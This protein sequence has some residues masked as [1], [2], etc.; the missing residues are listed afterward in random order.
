MVKGEIPDL[1]VEAIDESGAAIVVPQPSP[2][3]QRSW[4][5][6]WSLAGVSEPAR[7]DRLRAYFAERTRG[8]SL[9][10]ARRA[11]FYRAYYS[12]LPEDRGRP[13][14]RTVL[15]FDCILQ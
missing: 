7:E 14:I 15:L 8:T 10:H 3:T 12:V 11:R 4:G 2:R 6:A 5:V 13:P 1:W 9:E